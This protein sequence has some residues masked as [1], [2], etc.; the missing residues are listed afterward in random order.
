MTTVYK[1]LEILDE[2]LS[3]KEFRIRD[4]AFKYMVKKRKYDENAVLLE[5][6]LA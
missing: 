1:Y 3:S 2:D 4:A 6:L 5:R